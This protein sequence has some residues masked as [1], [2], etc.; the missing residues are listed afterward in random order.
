MPSRRKLEPEPPTAKAQPSITLL[1]RDYRR[2]GTSTRSV[3]LN[4]TTTARPTPL[5]SDT[6]SLAFSLSSAS[7]RSPS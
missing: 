6:V 3:K 5:S 4:F 1:S 7:S 2:R